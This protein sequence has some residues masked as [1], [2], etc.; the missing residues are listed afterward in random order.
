MT[1]SYHRYSYHRLLLITGV[2]HIREMSPG[3]ASKQTTT[4][5]APRNYT[6]CSICNFKGKKGN[7]LLTCA[8]CSLP[9]HLHCSIAS[10]NDGTHAA[11]EASDAHRVCNKCACKS[12]IASRR[13]SGSVTMATTSRLS[14]RRSAPLSATPTATTC[15]VKGRANGHPSGLLVK[16][17]CGVSNDGVSNKCNATIIIREMEKEVTSLKESLHDLQLLHTNTC[18]SLNALTMDHQRLIRFCS[19]L[20]HR[21][22]I[23][24]SSRPQESLSAFQQ[25]TA[26]V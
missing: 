3:S 14:T 21:I 5:V 15:N 9:V 24:E 18:Q 16:N 8:I 2:H 13:S 26:M 6:L 12:A 11:Q 7:R 4:T 10:T 23:I 19:E 17:N 25:L 22:D 1:H 20:R